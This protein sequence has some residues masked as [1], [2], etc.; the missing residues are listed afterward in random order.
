MIRERSPLA[1]QTVTIRADVPRLGGKQYVVEDWWQNVTGGSW[2][3]AE[4]N[5]AALIYAMRSGLTGIPTDNE[6][7]Y[8]KVDGL[9]QLVHVSELAAEPAAP[10]KPGREFLFVDTDPI[11]DGPED[12]GR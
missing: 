9:G 3:D 6:V 10:A 7:L 1:G 4:G 8:G 12:V 2:M 11:G 5:P